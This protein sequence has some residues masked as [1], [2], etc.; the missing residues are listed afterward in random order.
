[1]CEFC[2]DYEG[3]K[4]TIEEMSAPEPNLEE[5]MCAALVARTWKRNKNQ[6]G[7]R[8]TFE[9]RELNFCPE[10]GKKLANA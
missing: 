2:K 3:M 5:K 1:M 9:P 10:C 4:E 6:W 7:G 8:M